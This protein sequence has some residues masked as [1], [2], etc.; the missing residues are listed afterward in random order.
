MERANCATGCRD[1][2]HRRLVDRRRAQGFTLIEVVIALSII[3]L[4]TAV[5]VPAMARR[6]DAAFRAADLSRVTSSAKLLPAR[7][8]TLGIEFAL[9]GVAP[10]KALPDGRLPL[11]LPLGWTLLPSKMPPRFGRAGSC[12][13]GELI[14]ESGAP[15]QRWRLQ[16]SEMSCD[17][18]IQ[19]LE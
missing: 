15:I 1:L 10:V 4:V 8:A 3:A 16:F 5:T 6:L 2:I 11:D 17:L 7:A 12:S 13:A 19:L 9:D 14:V 18:Q